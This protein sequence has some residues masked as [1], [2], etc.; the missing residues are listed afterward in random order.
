MNIKEFNMHDPALLAPCGTN[1][2][3]CPYLIAYKTNDEHLKEKLAKSIGIKPEQIVCEGCRSDEPLF[4]CK[5]C[6]MKQC[7]KEKAIESCADCTDFPCK[8]IDKFPFKEFLKRQAWDVNYRK[9]YGK[10]KWLETTIK[11]NT[12]PACQNICHWRATICKECGTALDQR[13]I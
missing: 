11:M 2:G 9:Q 10:E 12:C 7:V 8:I 3:V 13:Y 1:C 6:G 5:M 4:F